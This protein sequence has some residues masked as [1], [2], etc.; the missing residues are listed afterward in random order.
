MTSISPVLGHFL[1]PVWSRKL[2]GILI[3]PSSIFRLSHWSDIHRFFF[4]FLGTFEELI[5]KVKWKPWVSPQRRL[6]RNLRESRTIVN[7]YPRN[8]CSRQCICINVISAYTVDVIYGYVTIN[9]ISIIITIL[10]GCIWSINKQ[11]NLY[12]LT[13]VHLV[14]ALSWLVNREFWNC[15]ESSLGH[16]ETCI[17]PNHQRINTT[18]HPPWHPWRCR[19][20][21]FGWFPVLTSAMELMTTFLS[22]WWQCCEQKLTLGC[23]IR[24]QMYLGSCIKIFSI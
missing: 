3:H 18:V 1:S 10:I 8:V 13:Q 9:I 11:S 4:F 6:D 20:R 7:L 12:V 23:W 22:Q 21:S 17:D 19:Q 2:E 15:S 14:H 16:V 5:R 24:L